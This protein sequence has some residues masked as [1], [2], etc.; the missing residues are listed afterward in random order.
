M[1]NLTMTIVIVI[2]ITEITVVVTTEPR[3]PRHK[4][5]ASLP[6]VEALAQDQRPNKDERGL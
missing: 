1:P 6:F 5:I 4:R 3:R 2:M